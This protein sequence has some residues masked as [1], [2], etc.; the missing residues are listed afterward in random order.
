MAVI[1][2]YPIATPKLGDLILGTSL[3]GK[4]PTKSYTVQSLADLVSGVQKIIAGTD[5]SISPADGLGTVT[6]NS[7]VDPGVTSIIAGD[8][9]N[10]VPAAGTGDVTI[11][12]SN[13]VLSVS[14]GDANTIL[15]GGTNIS[16]TVYANITSTI[17]SGGVNLVAAGT[18][19]DFVDANYIPYIE[20]STSQMQFVDDNFALGTSNT[21]VPTQLA[22]KT[23]VDNAVT[24]QLVYQG[25]YDAATNTPDLTTS[26]NSILKG[27]TYTVTTAGTFFTETVEV[28]DLLIAESD[29]PTSLSDWTTV[30]NNIGVA[31]DTIQGIA[32]FPISGG[33]SVAAG[34]VSLPDSGVIAGS[35]TLPDIIVDAKGRITS[36]SSGT[37]DIGVSDLS[38]TSGTFITIANLSLATGSI[39]LGTVDLSATGIPS[40]TTFLRGD[41]TWATVATE[42]NYVD[43]I[44]FNTADGVLTLERT[45]TLADLT[46]DLDGR[47][48]LI[49]DVPANIVQ[50]IDTTNSTFIN[51]TPASPTSGAVTVTAGLSATGTPDT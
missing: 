3:G 41:N 28:G 29:N 26:P 13:V 14:T 15:I 2:S 17:A 22:V 43:G 23:Y 6:I 47:Y 38:S 20:T 21:V 25:G 16:P 27:W 50:T 11:G 39:D 30:Q 24:G 4:N 42:D 10:L 5:I 12:V 19:Y 37:V 18:I 7:T 48:A 9:I 1:Y 40:T 32:N 51:L 31:T 36:A 34:A 46:Q 45:G 33:L 44:S 35:Y 8:N 49:A